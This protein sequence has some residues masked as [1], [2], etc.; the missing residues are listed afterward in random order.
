MPLIIRYQDL[1]KNSATRFRRVRSLVDLAERRCG[2]VWQGATL[3][4]Q[5]EI[6]EVLESCGATDLVSW[7]QGTPRVRIASNGYVVVGLTQL[8]SELTPNFKDTGTVSSD[9]RSFDGLSEYKAELSR[10]GAIAQVAFREYLQQ[11]E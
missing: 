2:E 5:G 6:H 4:S 3:L 1:G 10:L 8:L 9:D 7:D 11:K